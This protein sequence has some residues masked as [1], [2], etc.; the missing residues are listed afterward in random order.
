MYSTLTGH[1]IFKVLT[2]ESRQKLSRVAKVKCYQ[3]GEFL[4]KENE[5]NESLFLLLDGSVR[6]ESTDGE[7]IAV[8]RSGSVIGEISTSGISSPIANAIAGGTVKTIVLPL[9]MIANISSRET[10]FGDALRELGMQRVT[11]RLFDS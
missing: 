3:V 2:D 6:I 10:V 7:L 8:L 5:L 11:S 9:Q 4:I 1:D